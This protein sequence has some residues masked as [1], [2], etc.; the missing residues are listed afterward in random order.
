M[1]NPQNPH[2]SQGWKA[3]GIPPKI[4]YKTRMS[5]LATA[6]QHSFGSP[7]HGDQRRKRHKRNPNGEG[8]R[9]T[10]KTLTVTR[11]CPS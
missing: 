10:S 8:R 4:R 9:E 1:T 3:E 5:I 11:Y 2:H 6:I 7:S